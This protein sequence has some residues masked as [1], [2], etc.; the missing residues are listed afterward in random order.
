MMLIISSQKYGNLLCFQIC[1][2]GK[3]T[4]WP[5]DNM[6][7]FAIVAQVELCKTT[8]VSIF[9]LAFACYWEIFTLQLVLCQCECYVILMHKGQK[10][11][12]AR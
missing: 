1:E 9:H 12:G 11:A 3:N 2:H 10:T 7:G 4:A 5:L 8:Q 6:A